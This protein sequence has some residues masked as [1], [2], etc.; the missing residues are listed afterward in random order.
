MG[1][2]GENLESNEYSRMN[3]LHRSRGAVAKLE[4]SSAPISS[5]G[6]SG[7]RAFC[8]RHSPRPT[9]SNASCADRSIE[10]S[11]LDTK[12]WEILVVSQIGH[13]RC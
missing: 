10:A 7:L 8:S 1:H 12:Y 3:V 9:G 5:Q 13:A 6:Q 11:A 4:Q 2:V